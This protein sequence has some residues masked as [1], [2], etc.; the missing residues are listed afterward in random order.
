MQ[1][2][3]L[4]NNNNNNNNPNGTNVNG[5]GVHGSMADSGVFTMGSQY[6]QPST[7]DVAYTNGALR[8][9]IGG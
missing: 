3:G 5:N 9:V 2:N 1:M 6:Y 4:N 7:N 8:S